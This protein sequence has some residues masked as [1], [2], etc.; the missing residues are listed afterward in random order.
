MDTMDGKLSI[1]ATPIGN[2]GDFSQ[3][4]KATLLSADV[5]V[6]EDTRTLRSLLPEEKVKALLIRGD[7]ISEGKASGKVL[8][9]L[10]RGQHVALITDAGTPGISDPGYILVKKV[11]ETLPDVFIE[12]IPGPSALIAALSISGIPATP[13]TFFGFPPMK[14][15]RAGFF[16]QI[17]E[18]DHTAVIYESPHRFM[19]T[20]AELQEAAEESRI[21]FIARELTKMHEEGKYGTLTEIIGYYTSN[22]DKMRGEFVIVVKGK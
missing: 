12:T 16:K 11:R 20:L 18:L 2:L 1:V 6:A 22:P 4:A 13:F 21:V 14:K 10:E 5:I 17:T 9:S 15:G 7:A 19:K 8:E 3:R